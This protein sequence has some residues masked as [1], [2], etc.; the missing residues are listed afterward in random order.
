MK[1]GPNIL[2]VWL[3]SALAAIIVTLSG[4]W[5]EFNYETNWAYFGIGLVCV[6]LTVYTIIKKK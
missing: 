4:I 6:G 3:W 1:T 2:A 5:F